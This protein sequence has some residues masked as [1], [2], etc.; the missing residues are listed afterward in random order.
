MTERMK[1]KFLQIDRIYVVLVEETNKKRFKS[2]SSQ[3]TIVRVMICGVY[4]YEMKV[5]Q[6]FV[7]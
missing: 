2:A 6:L 5:S 1:K 7:E 3:V 4:E